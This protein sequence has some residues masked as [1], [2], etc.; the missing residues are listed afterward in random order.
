MSVALW[1]HTPVTTGPL[2]GPVPH[3]FNIRAHSTPTHLK[4]RAIHAGVTVVEVEAGEP[5]H[6]PLIGQLA[7]ACPS[8]PREWDTKTTSPQLQS[9][10]TWEVQRDGAS[11]E[12]QSVDLQWP[13]HVF[14]RKP[15][16]TGLRIAWSLQN[17]ETLDT[18]GAVIVHWKL[19][20]WGPETKGCSV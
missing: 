18:L 2:P 5:S 1:I 9:P 19:E 12:L 20:G 14:P 3:A 7:S 16:T 6:M 13:F 10:P 8:E 17:H 11:S 4:G 15:Q